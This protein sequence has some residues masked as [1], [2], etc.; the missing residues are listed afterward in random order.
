MGRGR[1]GIEEDT[2][3]GVEVKSRKHRIQWRLFLGVNFSAFALQCQDWG[4]RS[5]GG[6]QPAFLSRKAR[7]ADAGH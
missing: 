7:E 4:F 6:C 5:N 1:A 2:V 3:E